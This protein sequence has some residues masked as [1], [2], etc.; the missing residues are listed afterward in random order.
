MKSIAIKIA[1]L[2]LLL[3]V[4]VPIFKTQ[5]DIKKME[6]ESK[7]LAEQIE[8]YEDKV[9]YA[10][11]KYERLKSGDED[12]LKEH[13]RDNLGYYDP[14]EEIIYNDITD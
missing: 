10:K 11:D 2:S 4:S 6:A 3:F 1:F 9:E 13:V 8:Y 12:V 7:K 14:S 5:I